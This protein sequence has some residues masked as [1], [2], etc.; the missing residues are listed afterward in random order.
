MAEKKRTASSTKT[1]TTSASPETRAASEAKSARGR[2]SHTQRKVPEDAK[3][4][5]QMMRGIDFCMLTTRGASGRLRARPMSNNGEV[6]LHAGAWFFTYRSSAKVREIAKDANVSLSF[7]GG[8][9]RA[10]VWIHVEG[11][12]K[13]SDDLALKKKLWVP[14]LERWFENGPAG[15]EVMLIHVAPRRASFWSFEDQ[16][17]IAL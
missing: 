4:L 6:D 7:V 1:R 11:K 16:G 12:A 15:R 8:S 3:R 9:K 10:P 14:E 13:L 2:R 17:E 5:A